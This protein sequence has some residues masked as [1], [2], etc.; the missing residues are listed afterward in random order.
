[1]AM[2]PLRQIDTWPL[3]ACL[4]IYWSHW[5]I[6]E[7]VDISYHVNK[8]LSWISEILHHLLSSLIIL[9]RGLPILVVGGPVDMYT[10]STLAMKHRQGHR[11]FSIS[12]SGTACWM[13]AH[14]GLYCHVKANTAPL[15]YSFGDFPIPF[16][17]PVSKIQS[18]L[19]VFLHYFL[20]YWDQLF[21]GAA[22]VHLVILVR[23]DPL[24]QFLSGDPVL[25]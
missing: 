20:S 15:W 13:F 7:M 21:L 23:A 5:L 4:N 22:S 18:V 9:S 12:Q 14:C 24:N 19:I 10:D 8:D 11:K 16:L 3:L 6:T 2:L 25:R 1:M 17:P